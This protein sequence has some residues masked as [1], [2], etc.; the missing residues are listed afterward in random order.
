MGGRITVG[1]RR[2]RKGAVF[3]IE[4]PASLIAKPPAAPTSA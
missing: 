1:N 2:D 4:F 3:T